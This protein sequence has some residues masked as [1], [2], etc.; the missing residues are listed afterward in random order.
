MRVAFIGLGVMGYPMA[1]HLANAGHK[2]AVYNRTATSAVRW[3]DE[4]GGQVEMSPAAA[5]RDAQYVFVCVGDDDD[6]SAVCDGMVAGEFDFGFAVEWMR[7]D[8]RIALAEAERNGSALPVAKLVDSYYR[9]VQAQGG[10][11]WDTSSLMARL[12]NASSS[13]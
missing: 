1:G 2:V 12:S 13:E 3:S 9:D 10:N 4:Y 7:K 5:A 11:R 6:L 8:L